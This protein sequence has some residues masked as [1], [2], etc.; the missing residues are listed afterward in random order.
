MLKALLSCNYTAIVS[1]SVNPMDY[2]NADTFRQDYLCAELMSKY[3]NWD[4]GINRQTVA[5]EKF[6]QVE[7]YLKSIDL[8]SNPRLSALGKVSTL[9]AVE[10]TAVRK[11][12]KILGEVSI[13]EVSSRFA[14]GPGASTSLSRKRG[15]AAYKFGA[16]K[17]QLTYNASLLA[18]AA[19]AAYPSWPFQAE[20][21]AGARLTT[22]PKNAKT[23][24]VICVEPDLN[25]FFQKGLGAV[26]RRRLQRWGLLLPHAQQIN[27]EYARV[28]SANGR[29]ATVDLSSASDSIHL[30]LVQRLLPP[31]WVELIEQMRSPSV[32]LPSG[33]HVLL[34]K[35]S[36][37]GNGF[38]FELE[39]LIFYALSLAVI[40]LFAR[41]DSDRQCTVFGDDIVIA[42]E[43]VGVLT[44]VFSHL[45]FVVNTKK[46]FSEG[47]FRESCGKHY[48][49]GVDVSPFHID[50][51][52]DTIHRAYWAANSVR[53]WSRMHWGLDA[54]YQQCYENIV[55]AI[56]PFF[57]KFVIPEGVGDN[58]LVVDWDEA[59][60]SLSR[61]E[62]HQGAWEYVDL[63]PR[64]DAKRIDHPHG[65]LLKALHKLELSPG[66]ALISESGSVPLLLMQQ[67]TAVPT[68][69]ELLRKFSFEAAKRL[70]PDE[71]AVPSGYRK[72]KGY[73]HQWPTFGPWIS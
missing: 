46:T 23:D 8:D 41:P 43:L 30:G 44:E 68:R 37:M 51:P 63:T 49:N 25:M 47:P 17:P 20:V 64:F 6:W 58:G 59:R 70:D 14:F 56:P 18:Y 39:T 11:I 9:R 10:A 5:L 4:L 28:G 21:V 3:P 15:D 48:F 38:T 40:E 34:T 65:P 61:K 69:K 35:V 26:I 73:S 31:D 72:H 22:V 66:P 52:V 60:P 53:R 71:I 55:D 62:E 19:K 16:E 57:R 12:A 27:A 50:G 13:D 42:S 67:E 24:R 33:Q 45:G 32:V 7:H 2:T 29:L 36:S 1:A 54:R